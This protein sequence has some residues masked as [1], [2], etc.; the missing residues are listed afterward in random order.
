MNVTIERQT[1]NLRHRFATSQG[2]S[3]QRETLV[4]T[5]EHDGV[6]G[7]GEATPSPLYHQTI[8]SNTNALECAARMLGDDPFALEMILH[9]LLTRFDDQRAAIAALDSALH[10]W[11]GQRL[12]VPVWRL[13]GLAPP[14][15]PTAFTLGIA[16]LDALRVKLDEALADGQRVL[17]IKIGGDDD[18]AVLELI[19][20]RFG[21]PL[22][23][24][25]NQAW[26]PDDAPA[27]LRA[28]AT[29]EPAL[30]EQPLP[31]DAPPAAFA[32]L[33]DLRVAPIFVDESCVRAD[34]IVRLAGSVDGVNIK[35]AKCGG[36]REGL[37]MIRLAR[38][39]DLGVMLGC[40]VSSSLAIAP[41]LMLA[42]L[43]DF[44]DLDGALLLGQDPFTGILHDAGRL[45]AGGGPGL[46]VQPRGA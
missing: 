3:D 36:L 25:A 39:L 11:I 44:V 2:G 4:V 37:R 28:L 24:D 45:T 31:A 30:V 43:V 20:S 27:R 19:R 40:F 38:A 10:D 34:D 1:L 46:G 5:L 8:E 23:L 33:R 7:R 32:A 9:R 42:S 6:V 22:L 17:K 15:V 26:S 18:H 13:L 12:G 35:L 14:H 21:G 16:P 41:A 29:F